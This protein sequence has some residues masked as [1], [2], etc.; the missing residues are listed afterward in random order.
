MQI[1]SKYI[2][3][4]E[5]KI[6]NTL[7]VIKFFAILFVISAHMTFI[8][9]DIKQTEVVADSI[10]NTLGQIGVP[11]FFIVSGYFYR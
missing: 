4:C 1:K 7:Y 6:S 5:N 3:D 8:T 11:I 2:N 10:R 9:S